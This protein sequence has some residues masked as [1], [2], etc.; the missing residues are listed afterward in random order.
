MNI[1]KEC[2]IKITAW[3]MAFVMIIT[4]IGITPI[5][6]NAEE[7]DFFDEEDEVFGRTIVHSGTDGGV[8]WKVYSD[9]YLEVKITG[10]LSGGEESPWGEAWPW[11]PYSD[12]IKTAKVYGYGLKHADGMFQENHA[13]TYIDFS[14]LNTST[15]V[16]MNR[17]FYWAISLKELDLSGFDTRNVG[18][19]WMMFAGCRSLKKLNVKGFDTRN[20]GTI[21]MMFSHCFSLEELDLSSFDLSGISD[22]EYSLYNATSAALA[23]NGCS[24]LRVLKTPKVISKNE[25]INLP[26]IFKNKKGKKRTKITDTSDVYTKYASEMLRY[27]NPNSGEHFYTSSASEAYNIVDSGWNGEGVAWYAPV[28]SKTPVYRLYN[29]N[30][31]DHHYT[32]SR[33]EKENLVKAGWKYEGIGWYSD[34]NKGVP[35]YR[36]Y[37]PNAKAGAHHYTTSL[38]E[39]NKLAS[40]G[41]KYEG[42]A[43]YGVK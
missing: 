25:H 23:L 39:K 17:M 33:T 18:T 22:E 8:K 21:G 28:K 31:G 43:W 4:F 11:F 36:L 9:G 1:K 35:L 2:F 37:N 34:D 12:S 7:D 38:S 27:Y 5:T 10:D 14:G 32:T 15:V 30:A 20:V 3:L 16:S 13:V 24:S 40:A 41:W 26:G 19:M 42:I 29:P 6:I